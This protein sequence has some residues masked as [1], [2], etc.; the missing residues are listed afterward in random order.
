MAR[1]AIAAGFL[2]PVF[3]NETNTSDA[4][5]AGPLYVDQTIAVVPPVTVQGGEWLILMRRRIRRTT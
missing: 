3:V 4:I 1:Q 2:Q 5:T